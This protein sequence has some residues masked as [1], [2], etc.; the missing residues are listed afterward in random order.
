[1]STSVTSARPQEE[2]PCGLAVG[3][4]V[5]GQLL[6]QQPLPVMAAA[7]ESCLRGPPLS[8]YHAYP[9]SKQVSLGTLVAAKGLATS[10][11]EPREVVMPERVKRTSRRRNLESAC[12]LGHQRYRHGRLGFPSVGSPLVASLRG[13]RSCSMDYAVTCAAIDRRIRGAARTRG[14]ADV[15]R[16]DP[17]RQLVVRR[18]ST[19]TQSLA[20]PKRVVTRRRIRRSSAR[21]RSRCWRGARSFSPTR[22]V[23]CLPAPWAAS[24]TTTRASS[25][26]GR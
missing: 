24:F 13:P 19:P 11:V 7:S 16:R 6:H 5:Q 12:S 9:G 17:L 14:D 25:T 10:L 3:I 2:G 20:R 22:S 26:G 8:C 18:R 21:M 4:A 15:T 23:T 1:M